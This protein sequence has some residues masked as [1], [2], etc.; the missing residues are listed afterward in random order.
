MFSSYVR[1]ERAR[2]FKACN[3]SHRFC[4]PQERPPLPRRILQIS[5]GIVR[6]VDTED[7]SLTG[8]YVTL[9]YC[10]GDPKALIQ[11]TKSTLASRQRTI[12]WSELPRLFEDAIS[13]TRKIGIEFI[14]IDCLCIV[15][16]DTPEWETEAPKM[17][18][19]YSESYLT[20]AA[21]RCRGPSEGL[22][23]DRPVRKWQRHS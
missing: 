15:Q 14:W 21:T 11:T 9:S 23:S 16:D 19:Y 1:Y 5:N 8:Q 13:I 7:T 17:S 6:L 10:W 20:I 2:Y 12:P 18:A 3:S 22:F 4:K